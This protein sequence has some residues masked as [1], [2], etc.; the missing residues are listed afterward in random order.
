VTGT[1]IRVLVVDDHPL[2]LEGVLR[3][4]EKEP[5][6]SAVAAAATGEEAIRKFRA[7]RPH[8]T[9]MDLEL[10][11]MSGVDTIMAIRA[12]TPT[13]R[14]VVLT[15]YSG[16]D[17]VF[18]AL[19]AGASAYVLKDAIPD[20]LVRTIRSV[21]QGERPLS[22]EISALVKAASARPGLTPRETQVLTLL[23]EGKTDKEIADVLRNSP[24]T[25]H[26]HL[27][28]I[29]EKLDVHDRTAAVTTAIRRGILHLPR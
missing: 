4:L 10:G 13:A 20:E 18:R 5:D 28:S 21:H 14:F 2:M 27:R 22:P 24:R 15:M 16:Q 25:I 6:L 3:I 9:V 8:V 23:A 11:G 29:F 12:E 19:D 1:P 17:D 26:V 7:H